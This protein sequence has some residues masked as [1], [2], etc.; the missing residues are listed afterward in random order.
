MRGTV[1]RGRGR[2]ARGGGGLYHAS[3]G[4]YQRASGFLYD[5]D[6]RSIGASRTWS[7][8]NGNEAEWNT[9]ANGSPSPRKDFSALRSS[10][11][12]ESWRRSRGEDDGLYSF[13]FRLVQLKAIIWWIWR[14]HVTVQICA[15][16]CLRMFTVFIRTGQ[17]L[18]GGTPSEGWRT[19][20][21][22]AN[23]S[24]YKWREYIELI[25]FT[26]SNWSTE[27]TFHFVAHFDLDEI[28]FAQL[29]HVRQ[30]SFSKSSDSVN[31]LARR[32]RWSECWW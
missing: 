5:E 14:A 11:S 8:R 23:N 22:S 21:T 17:L 16:N 19:S 20:T 31:Q 12:G 9:T 24:V 13:P 1:D 27:Q 15:I 2:T 30:L 18:N 3:L 10:S 4:G 29:F 25:D 7:E 32:R 28:L 26:Q 6:S